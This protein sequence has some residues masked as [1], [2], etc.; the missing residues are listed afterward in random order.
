VL[1]RDV[2]RGRAERD[3][4]PPEAEKAGFSRVK[5]TFLKKSKYRRLLDDA[6]V[7]R[8]FRNNLR[9]SAVT[10]SEQLR[11][12]GWIC[13]HFDTTPRELAR[14]PCRKAEDFLLDSTKHIHL[15]D[16]NSVYEAEY[17]WSRNFSL[18]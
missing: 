8:W 16:L 10:A 15:V 14:L 3:T 6:E 9:G 13:K 1:P 2:R 11:R 18:V 4:H 7:S 5:P 12:L 17:I